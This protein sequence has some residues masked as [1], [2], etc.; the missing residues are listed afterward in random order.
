M[1]IS[2]IYIYNISVLAEDGIVEVYGLVLA[3]SCQARFSI[4]AKLQIGHWT[5]TVVEHF[6]QLEAAYHFIC[7]FHDEAPPAMSSLLGQLIGVLAS[8]EFVLG[9]ITALT[10]TF[11]YSR[12]VQRAA[13]ASS[14]AT[15]PKIN[16]A[17]VP[18]KYDENTKMVILVRSDL[19]MTK[20][21]AAAQ[22][23]HAVLAAYKD[24]FKRDPGLLAAWERSGQ[25]KVT[26]KVESE[27]D[28]MGLVKKAREYGVTA[29]YI[30]DAGRTQV[31]PNTTTVAAVGP[32]PCNLLDLITGH[33]KLY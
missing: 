6:G 3:G 18:K 17:V 10:G 7:Q 22:A 27:E 2:D 29:Q 12:L 28:L 16:P 1:N 14:K 21:K 24:V 5:S 31:A 19:N 23:C 9:M 33:L 30:R 32:A 15:S 8:K 25:A 11:L 4:S 13:A 20:G 26:L